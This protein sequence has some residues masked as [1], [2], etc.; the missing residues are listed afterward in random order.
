MGNRAV[1][2]F[3]GSKT[4]IYLHWNGG[5]SSVRAFLDCARELG[6]RDPVRDSYGIARLIQ[7]IGNFFGGSLSIGVGALESLDQNNFDNGVYWIGKDWQIVKR[8]YNAHA[9]PFNA[10]YYAGVYN[11]VME[12]NYPLF[13]GEEYQKT[14][15]LG[16]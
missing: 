16:A 4:G 13:T 6:V 10:D 9:E 14:E 15:I 8:E 7:I 12:K 3:E 1:I 11:E 5:E 2:A